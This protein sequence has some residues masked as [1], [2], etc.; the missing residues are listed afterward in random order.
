MI[1][2][3]SAQAS[4]RLNEFFV[5]RTNHGIAVGE[6]GGYRKEAALGTQ[7]YTTLVP[8]DQLYDIAS[9]V[10]GLKTDLSEARNPNE[11]I[12]LIERKVKEAGYAGYWSKHPTLGLVAVTFEKM[13]TQ[14]SEQSYAQPPVIEHDS[15]NQTQFGKVL[16]EMAIERHG[17]PLSEKSEENKHIISDIMVEEILEELGSDSAAVD[18]YKDSIKAAL[19]HAALLHPEIANDPVQ[20]QLFIMTIALT[21]NGA[22]IKANVQNA[23]AIYE[24]YKNTG[25]FLVAAGGGS[26][27]AKNIQVAF[28]RLAGL[29]ENL[30]IEETF[31]F[32]DTK[33][34]ARDLEKMGFTISGE[35][36]DT[37]VYGSSVFGPKIGGGFYQNL[38][39]NHDVLTM[40][41]W[42]M[43]SWGRITG[44]IVNPKNGELVLT[45]TSGGIRQWIREV[46]E[47]ARV[48][49]ADQGV[50]LDTAAIQAMLWYR[51]KDFY[52]VNGMNSEK[53]EATDYE[54]EFQKLVER[55]L[56]R[57]APT[58]GGGL[59]PSAARLTA[60]QR[61]E[62]RRNQSTPFA[63]ERQGGQLRG[64][65]DPVTT[66]IRLTEAS[67]LSTFLHEFAHFML[68][69]EIK[70]DGSLMPEIAQ[71]VSRNAAA[72]AI[73][74]NTYQEDTLG[75]ITA[76]DVAGFAAGGTLP[77]TIDESVQRA[78]HEQ[79]ARG[80]E[81]YL[82]EGVSPSVELRNVFRTIARWMQQIYAAISGGIDAN[83]DADM[84][85]VFDRLIATEE[86]I[87]AAQARGKATPMF[88]DAAMAGMSEEDFEEKLNKFL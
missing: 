6:P 63:Q 32:M 7:K 18:W 60:K 12:N 43:K 37:E 79:F 48:K 74:A 59:A 68:D 61:A 81:Q 38:K 85:Q 78:I 14:S 25:E 76:E 57:G 46:V 58:L 19:G 52:A 40:D 49:L 8:E 86:Q 56:E 27:R 84:R 45:P 47:E 9:D 24:H 44:T 69:Q 50:E 51:E 11:R 54:N 77:T 33:F 70:S 72:I 66:T 67:D 16:D 20:R 87:A 80:F 2:L 10:D 17:A 83:V 31:K 42:F 30:G 82:M 3:S 73:E 39:G 1:H 29:I 55:K 75:T 28:D 36:K 22:P 65:Y 71:W 64:E 35:N 5:D 21:S 34:T 23:D 13:A 41:L 4:E 62:V 26:V 88:T 15:N 53:G